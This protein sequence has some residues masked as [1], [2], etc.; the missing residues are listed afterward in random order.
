MDRSAFIFA[1]KARH[2]GDP[3]R[4]TLIGLTMNKIFDGINE[5]ARIGINLEVHEDDPAPGEQFPAWAVHSDGREYL[6]ESAEHL[7]ALGEG[8]SLKQ[9]TPPADASGHSES[10]LLYSSGGASSEKRLG[11]YEHASGGDTLQRVRGDS[12][13]PVVSLQAPYAAPKG[14]MT[15]AQALN[16]SQATQRA[17]AGEPP[18][19]PIYSPEK[20]NVEQAQDVP[21]DQPDAHSSDDVPLDEQ[22]SQ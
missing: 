12:D 8:W 11:D 15:D 22:S 13:H 10:D 7:D 14:A 5:L 9:H 20:G 21:V 3:Q 17:Q 16:Q 6:V 4:E 18:P 1:L 2:A 19:D